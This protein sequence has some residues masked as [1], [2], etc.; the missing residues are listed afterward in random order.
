MNIKEDIFY[1]CPLAYYSFL[2]VEVDGSVLNGVVFAIKHT[3][4]ECKIN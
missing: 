1:I 2:C 3:V 4:I